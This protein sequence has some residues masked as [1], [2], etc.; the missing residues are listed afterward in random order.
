MPQHYTVEELDAEVARRPGDAG[1]YLF[2]KFRDGEPVPDGYKSW[3]H[4][5]EDVEKPKALEECLERARDMDPEERRV[6]RAIVDGFSDSAASQ[7]RKSSFI[8]ECLERARDMDPEERRVRRAIVDVSSGSAAGQQMLSDPDSGIS[9]GRVVRRDVGRGS[10]D[11]SFVE[12]A[13]R[14]DGEDPREADTATRH[15]WAGCD[16]PPSSDKAPQRPSGSGIHL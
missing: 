11:D 5:Y 10:L 2:L 3:R 6:R 7:Q 4:W 8:E 15:P 16:P 13:Y 14:A 1:F 9:E 12:T